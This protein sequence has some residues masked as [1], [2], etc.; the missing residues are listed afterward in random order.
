M[1]KLVDHLPF[2]IYELIHLAYLGAIGIVNFSVFLA[3]GVFVYQLYA[4]LRAGAWRSIFAYDYPEL[5]LAIG[6]VGRH[7]RS[8]HRL[9]R[10][11][12]DHRPAV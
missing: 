10:R 12:K 9:G 2:A 5:L 3:I 6:L 1:K 7:C 11:S 4:W 8:D